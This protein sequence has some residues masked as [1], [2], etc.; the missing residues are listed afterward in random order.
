MNYYLHDNTDIKY[1]NNILIT[2]ES[3]QYIVHF[4]KSKS[5]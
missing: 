4:H 3:I 1:K 5:S 2:N